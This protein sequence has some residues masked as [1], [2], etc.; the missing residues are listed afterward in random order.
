REHEPSSR[1]EHP[2]ALGHRPH[3]VG[4]RHRSPV[5]EDEVERGVPEREP[6]RAGTYQGEAYV[7]LPLEL[8]GLRE[9]NRRKVEAR[10]P[11]PSPSQRD[12]PTGRAATELQDGL[13]SRIPKKTQ[14]GL[15]YPE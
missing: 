12:R 5:A 9:L 6:F 7:G 11:G 2:G 14:L 3:R 1:V 15:R 8:S 10:R 13:P 4:E